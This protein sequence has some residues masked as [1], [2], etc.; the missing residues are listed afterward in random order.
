MLPDTC[1]GS[2]RTVHFQEHDRSMRLDERINTGLTM[3]LFRQHTGSYC[4]ADAGESVR[5]RQ[6]M[7]DQQTKAWFSGHVE[8]C[9]NSLYGLAFRLTRNAA[10]A[11]DLVG[12]AV[13]KAW[14]ALAT[15]D[16][17]GRFRAWL[18]R[19]LHNC[20]ISDYRKKS[21][22]PVE[23]A[24]DEMASDESEDDVSSFLVG[25]SDD[26]L[27]WWANPEREFANTMLGEKIIEAIDRLPD[28]FR[29]TVVL[30]NVEGLS[31][32]EAAEVLGVPQ[33]TVR[34]RM[35]RGRTML[36]RELWLYGKEAGLI[37]DNAGLKV[38]K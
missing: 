34:S 25:Q 21:V 28:A 8:G 16:D 29:I 4:R 32:D 17:N 37:P 12:D 23:M 38:T 20:F 18:F 27:Q 5:K 31:Y 2:R 3:L 6:V 35:K 7:T 15:L 19:I 22:R 36:Q 13:V 26:F 1:T 33:G 24:F 11:E 30:V 14:S 10:D 9:M